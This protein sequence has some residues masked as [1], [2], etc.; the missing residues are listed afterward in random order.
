MK[1][2]GRRIAALFLFVWAAYQA[3]KMIQ[4][5]TQASE[6]SNE[7]ERLKKRQAVR[8]EDINRAR[9][10]LRKTAEEAAESKKKVEAVR[11]RVSDE[12]P[13]LDTTF[14]NWMRRVDPEA[15]QAPDRADR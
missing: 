3:W 9:Q 1:R 2:W 4:G 14:A 8:E 6:L 10:E 15:E 7:V 12:L 11:K 13:D 5:Y